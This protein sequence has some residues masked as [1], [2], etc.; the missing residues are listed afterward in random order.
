MRKILREKERSAPKDVWEL[1][2]EV[3]RHAL[4]GLLALSSVSPEQN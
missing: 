3:F 1:F 2:V 4:L